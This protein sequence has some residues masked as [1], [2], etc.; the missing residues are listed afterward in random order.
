MAAINSLQDR[1]PFRVWLLDTTEPPGVE[2][3]DRV[4]PAER[5][6]CQCLSRSSDRQAFIHTRAALR[7]V[8]A[9]VLAKPV[10]SITFGQNAWG[11][12]FVVADLGPKDINFNVSHTEG[13]SLIA[14][15]AGHRIGV[16]IERDRVLPDRKDIAIEVFGPA[17]A[18]TLCALDEAIQHHAFLR[19]WTTAEAFVK[20]TGTGFA[21][22]TEPIPVSIACDT[23]EIKLH[24]DSASMTWTHFPLALP[25][26]YYGSVVVEN[27]GEGGNTI[28]PEP[29]Y[30]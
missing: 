12:P 25:N 28:V 1:R 6:R 7:G 5:D 10:Q 15:S 4:D 3:L 20:A 9:D 21:G 22:R 14:L 19:L 16:D 26:G 17:V 11:K 27:L 13:L 23:G 24:S 30:Q 18:E 2:H 29:L 8:L